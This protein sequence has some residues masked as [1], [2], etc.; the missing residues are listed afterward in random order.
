MGSQRLLKMSESLVVGSFRPRS[1]STR[2]A[3]PESSRVNL[4]QSDIDPGRPPAKCPGLPPSASIS[5]LSKYPL[6]TEWS[7][8]RA[9][10]PAIREKGREGLLTS[11]FMPIHPGSPV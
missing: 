8:I 4:I 1:F 9:H 3:L 10:D 7:V 11:L 2:F 5:Q 6:W